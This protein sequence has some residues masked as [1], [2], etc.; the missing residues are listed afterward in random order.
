MASIGKDRNGRRRILFVASD[1]R[2]KTIRLGKVTAKQAAAFKVRLE[3]LVAGQF[4]GIDDE[5]ARWVAALPNDMHGRL[6]AVGLVSPRAKAVSLTLG[7]FLTEYRAGRCD[8]KP[9]TQLV[10]GRTQ[11]HLVDHFGA[12][13]LLAD[14]TEGDADEWRLYLVSR[15]LAEN[16]VRRTCGIARQ[17]FRAAVR[18]RVIPAN[19][20]S[21][22]KVSVKGNPARA[23]FISR[24]DSEKI[25]ASCP[26]LEWKLIYAL[27][28]Y[29]GLRTPSETLLLRW[30]DIDWEAG[31]MLVHSP[32]TEAHPGGESRFVPLF[33]E[34]APLLREAFT[35]AE[36]GDGFVIAKHRKTGM[37]L[38][39]HLLRI[40]AK[41]GVK[42]WP[43]L[44]QNLRSTRQTELAESWPEYVVCA[45]LGNSKLV[46]REH[47]LQVTERHFRQAAQLPESAAQ[48]PAQYTFVQG[49]NIL[50]PTPQDPPENADLQ[51]GTTAS[52]CLQDKELGGRGLEPLTPS[53]S[54]W[55]S[56]QLS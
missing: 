44:L 41:A 56:S 38:R 1:G 22:L 40:M 26:S 53:V 10:Y 47:Y 35:A 45:W 33:P 11:K 3:A 5:T 17:F 15:G 39:T 54:S 9:N 8:V 43:K 13:R 6:A 25:L 42:Q 2:R 12:D 21:E 30:R 20:F 7:Q 24:A 36:P 37:N 51:V 31:K 32:K 52:K 34:L 50:T 14:I 29:G 46:A 48:N 28:R 23:F 49:S 16:T 27:A 19:P 18:R 4:S 55:C